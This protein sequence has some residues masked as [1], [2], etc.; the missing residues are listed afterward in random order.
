MAA[1]FFGTFVEQVTASA[2]AEEAPAEA[3]AAAVEEVSSGGVSPMVWIAGV[4]AV[5]VV[6]LL[7][8]NM[9]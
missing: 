4:I 9:S 2:A 3:P 8:L 5:V 7:W 1:Q 6:V